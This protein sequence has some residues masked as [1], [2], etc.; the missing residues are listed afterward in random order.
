[1]RN[2]LSYTTVIVL[3]FLI[4]EASAQS[5]LIPYKTYYPI[6]VTENQKPNFYTDRMKNLQKNNNHIG[7]LAFAFLAKKYG[8]KRH[9]KKADKFLEEHFNK[10]IQAAYQ[11]IEKLEKQT[12]SFSTELSAQNASKLVAL[13]KDMALLKNLAKEDNGM[14]DIKDYSN[15]IQKAE[16]NKATYFKQTAQLYFE[17]AKSARP[18]TKAIADYR[19]LVKKLNR[20]LKYDSRNDITQLSEELKPY[21][22]TTL[23]IGTVTDEIYNSSISV[24]TVREV[25]HKEIYRGIQPNKKARNPMPP[26]PFFKL[27]SNDIAMT[28]E[29]ADVLV[30]LIIKDVSIEKVVDETTSK[31][32]SQTEGEGDNKKTYKAT[33]VTHSKRARVVMDG[34]YRIKERKTGKVVR[35]DTVTG[36]YA[37]IDYWHNYK[38]SI[39]G[40]SKSQKNMVRKKELPY[41]PK[42]ELIR[43]GATYDGACLGSTSRTESIGIYS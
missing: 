21:A 20:A 36:N 9:I 31:E 14:Y 28:S 15:A 33:L 3:L 19:V 25:I 35:E 13:Y 5:E 38:G 29:G 41:P 34:M 8:K 27:V 23:G 24:N 10:N 7:A 16:E 6:Q 26:L 37:W 32:V 1:M 22:I 11:L 43:S 12:Q 4:I 42:T 30:E 18:N 2:A 40:L 17:E 39:K